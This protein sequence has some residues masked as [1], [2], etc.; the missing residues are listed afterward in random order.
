[1]V[2][3][4]IE[5]KIKKPLF[6]ERE[7][8]NE[9]YNN[10]NVIEFSLLNH[11]KEPSH[12]YFR[13][14]DYYND[15][16]Y[17]FHSNN[18]GNI[19]GFSVSSEMIKE[20]KDLLNEKYLIFVLQY[21]NGKGELKNSYM[22][23]HDVVFNVFSL[24]VNNLGIQELND[25]KIERTENEE[26]M[27]YVSSKVGYHAFFVSLFT[28]FMRLSVLPVKDKITNHVET[29][30]DLIGVYKN[31]FNYNDKMFFDAY[32]NIFIDISKYYLKELMN[33][34][35]VVLMKKNTKFNNIH[36]K[37]WKHFINISIKPTTSSIKEICTTKVDE[38]K[39]LNDLFLDIEKELTQYKESNT[40]R[41][42][43]TSIE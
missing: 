31:N 39:N 13:C 38:N 35:Y 10:S 43:P 7:R 9:I 33:D 19:Y 22:N 26:Y 2:E 1:M 42:S 18:T 6:K 14:K 29:F 32:S 15:Y 27:F 21:R 3:E 11:K 8:Y 24:L 41:S 5:E 25:F 16:F 23:T 4:K 28:T 12:G 34:S 30:E 40:E 20:N 36:D 37:G 17:S